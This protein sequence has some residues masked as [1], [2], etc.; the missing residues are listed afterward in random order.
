MTQHPANIVLT[1]LPLPGQVFEE[2]CLTEFWHRNDEMRALL[3]RLTAN[4]VPALEG[5][6]AFRALLD[7]LDGDNPVI[8]SDN[9]K[10]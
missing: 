5:I 7:S 9:P 2:R 1:S 4:P 10:L 3:T 8:L 6:A